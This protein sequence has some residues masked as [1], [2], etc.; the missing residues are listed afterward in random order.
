MATTGLG[1]HEDRIRVTCHLPLNN[2][3]EEKAVLQCISYLKEQRTAPVGVKGFTHSVFRPTAFRGCWWSTLHKKWVA[4]K[5]VLCMIDYRLDF[6]DQRLSQTVAELKDTI[7]NCYRDC[8]SPQEE[9]WV[10]AHH[11]IRQD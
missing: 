2:P 11:V 9:V 6:G 3:R 5:I 4:E 1:L 7:R 10:V 8:G